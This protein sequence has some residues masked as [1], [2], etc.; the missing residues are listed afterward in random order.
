MDYHIEVKFC[1]DNHPAETIPAGDTAD[2][3]ATLEKLI[4]HQNTLLEIRI[5]IN[6]SSDTLGIQGKTTLYGEVI[7]IGGAETPHIVLRQL[8]GTLGYFQVANLGL[9]QKLG[10]RI[11][12]RVGVYGTATWDVNTSNLLD[13]SIEEL[14]PYQ[15]TPLQDAIQSFAALTHEFYEAVPDIDAMID[16]A[17]GRNDDE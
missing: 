8:D 6:N 11:Y 16:E 5:V 13:F 17:R 9:A 12:T 1:G 15:A 4:A 10:E 14:T 3:F 7:S 2:L